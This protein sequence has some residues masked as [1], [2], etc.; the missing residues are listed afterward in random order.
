MEGIKKRRERA[1]PTTGGK[2]IRYRSLWKHEN[3]G[4]ARTQQGAQRKKT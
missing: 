3:T 4:G 2:C 1:I